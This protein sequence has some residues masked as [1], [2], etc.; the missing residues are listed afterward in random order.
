MKLR[1]AL[2]AAGCGIAAAGAIAAPAKNW[3]TTTST[4][5][6]KTFVIGNP[7]AK[8]KLVEYLSYTC[9]HC[10]AFIKEASAP[11]KRDYVAK[12]LASIEVR[13]ALRDRFDFTA[14]LLARCDGPAAFLG[15]NEAIFAAQ[16]D[17]I[18][19]GVAFER[20][21]GERL[22]T[23]S[24]SATLVE[25]ARGSGLEA[26]MRARGMAPAKINACL[27]DATQHEA[28][29]AMADEAW[30]KRQIPG[31]PSFL[32]NGTTVSN[33]GTWTALKPKIDAVIN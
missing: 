4:T 24:M 15:H 5:E 16:Q 21:N 14:A 29:A 31:T 9:D 26:L 32:L 8:A 20:A 13:H 19:K 2:F 22:K 28:L 10:A 25:I 12:G 23:L 1:L 33:V 17:W 18:T 6:S 30:S 7:A 27:T 3:L 11:L